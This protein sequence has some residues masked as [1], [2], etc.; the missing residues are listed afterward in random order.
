MNGAVLPCSKIQF[1]FVKFSFFRSLHESGLAANTITT[2]KSALNK[3]F[4]YGFDIDLKDPRYASIP[5]SCA[6]LRPTQRPESFSWSLNEVLRLASSTDAASCQYQKCFRKRG[7]QNS[8]LSRGTA[9]SSL[10][11]ERRGLPFATSEVPG[12]EWGSAE[13]VEALE[14]HTPST[15]PFIMPRWDPPALSQQDFCLEKRTPLP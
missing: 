1:S 2:T 8:R 5:K 11:A 14:D 13:K 15:E 4:Y 10:W 6:R 12:Q 7:Y 3:I 9:A